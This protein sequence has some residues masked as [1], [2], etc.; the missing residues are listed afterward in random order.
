MCQKALLILYI[1][2]RFKVFIRILGLAMTK[3][4]ETRETSLK[5][6]VYQMNI[7]LSI[8]CVDYL[9]TKTTDNIVHYKSLSSCLDKNVLIPLKKKNVSLQTVLRQAEYNH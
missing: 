4:K 1:V 3:W 2:P 6:S 7:R 8:I 5:E 9:T